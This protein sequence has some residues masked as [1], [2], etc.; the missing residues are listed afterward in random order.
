MVV[1]DPKEA[2]MAV[3]ESYG[4]G[5]GRA[6]HVTDYCRIHSLV[7][8]IAKQPP[9][10]PPPL[11]P[12]S[13]S[14]SMEGTGEEGTGGKETGKE[15]AAAK[16]EEEEEEAPFDAICV[17]T[18]PLDFF[19]ALQAC[20]DVL[21]SPV[22]AGRNAKEVAN[23]DWLLRATPA[24]SNSDGDGDGSSGDIGGGGC[25]VLFSNPDL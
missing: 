8:P 11:P 4:L 24:N 18:D 10:P 21:L 25:H 5:S 15:E 7:N 12:P 3:A 1:G 13:P 2:V 19:E 14:L 22:P 20:T 6:I 17:F 9:P 23:H 16:E